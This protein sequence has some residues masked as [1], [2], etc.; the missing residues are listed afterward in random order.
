MRTKRPTSVNMY[1]G[2]ANLE[3]TN[4]TIVSIKDM[5]EMT[6]PA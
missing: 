6:A 5:I 3:N 4:V 1:A 2:V